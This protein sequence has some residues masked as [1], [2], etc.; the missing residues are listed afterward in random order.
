[1]PSPELDLVKS[2]PAARLPPAPNSRNLLGKESGMPRMWSILVV[3]GVLAYPGCRSQCG[4]PGGYGARVPPPGTGSYGVPNSYYP[5]ATPRTSAAPASVAPRA[6]NPTVGGWRSASADG[7]NSV[8]S[9][10][11]EQPPTIA[12]NQVV[13]TQSPVATVRSTTAPSSKLR[14]MP[15]NE[16]KH[17]V[18]TASF[19]QPASP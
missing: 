17:P 15:V 5:A 9:A 13:T 3:L 14:G 11:A 16:P 6:T 7:T 10:A 12:D 18:S 4:Y 1:M 19:Q 8:A 2:R